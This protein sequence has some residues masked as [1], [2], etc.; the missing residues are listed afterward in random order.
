[1]PATIAIFDADMRYLA[2]SGRFLSMSSHLFSRKPPSP[3]EVVGHSHW[4]IF[5]DMPPHWHEVDARVLAG[6]AVGGAEELVPRKDGGTDCV[7]WSMKPWRAADGQIRGALLFIELIT[8]Q[9][10]AK[11]ALAESEPRFRT[12]FENA[13]VGIAHVSSDLRWLRANQALCRI[14]GWLPNEVIS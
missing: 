10:A 3:A 6:E 8:E 9:V 7:R 2:A 4:K 13:A 11:R 5:P 1:L 12:T 14:L